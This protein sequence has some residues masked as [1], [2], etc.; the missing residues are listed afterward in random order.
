MTNTIAFNTG[1]TYTECGQRI[2]A[3]Q[4][5]SGHI[6]MLDIDRGIDCL[7]TDLTPFNQSGIMSDYD[8]ALCIFP[9]DVG[10]D[11]SDYYA[12]LADLR[13]VANDAPCV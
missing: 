3:R 11:Y 8:H 7:F 9:S 12:V 10:L 13:A 1:R 6:V 5:E 4:L 2:A